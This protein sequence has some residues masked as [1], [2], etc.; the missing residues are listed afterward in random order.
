MF[1]EAFLIASQNSL[2]IIFKLAHQEYSSHS[3]QTST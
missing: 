3:K 2:A 1:M